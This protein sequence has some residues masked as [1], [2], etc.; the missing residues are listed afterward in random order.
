MKT[1]ILASWT[2]IVTGIVTL[3]ILGAPLANFI[4]LQ[5]FAKYNNHVKPVDPNVSPTPSPTP[6]IPPWYEDQESKPFVTL[7]RIAIF[8][9]AA[10]F[11]ALGA[12][13]SIMTR[14]G[15]LR[16]TGPLRLITPARILSAQIVGAVFSCIL[17]FFFAGGL[18]QG[19][20]FPTVGEGKDWF[21]VI[22]IHQ[23]FFKLLVWSF[24]GGFSE[25]L[26]PQIFLAFSSRMQQEV[27]K[28]S[29]AKGNETDAK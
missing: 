11:G 10:F 13:M 26:A 7:T 2:T 6:P 25:R 3:A 20:L 8:A 19:A 21:M 5:T 4:R 16:P 27:Q 17:A 12:T 24:L 22:Y 1:K 18:I 9:T 23:E 29:P 15:I 28:E 14:R